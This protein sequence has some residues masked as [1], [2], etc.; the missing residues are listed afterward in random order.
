MGTQVMH[1]SYT[2]KA[3][4]VWR[5]RYDSNIL[6]VSLQT[7]DESIA[8]QRSAMLTIRFMELVSM[9]VVFVGMRET[10]KRYRDE[11]VRRDKLKIL[12]SLMA[13]PEAS[14]QANQGVIMQSLT[15]EQKVAQIALERE[16][17]TVAGHTLEEAKKAFFDANTEWKPKTIKDYSSCIDRFLVWGVANNITIIEEVSKDNIIQFKAYM[18][19]VGLASNTKQKILTR[20]GSMFNFAV[21]VKDWIAKNPIQGMMYKKVKVEH[22]KEEITPEQFNAVMEQPTVWNDNQYKWAN[23]ICYY[24]GI[25]VGELCQLTKA[26]YVEIEG[27]KCISVNTLEE[28]KSTKTES[29]IRNIPL[30]DKLLDM[31]IW[32]VKPVMKTG[33]NSVM[34]KISKSYKLIGLKRTSHCYRHSLSNRL[35]DT[36]ADDSTRAFIL[37]HA[38]ATMTDRVYVTREPLIKMQRAL[39]EAN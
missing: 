4:Y 26:D 13:S 33:L 16:L 11:L 39:N 31:G 3:G 19:E 30:C 1:T 28:G 36:S 9:G 14:Q 24:T 20:L 18:D 6:S 7:Q 37:G 12:T 32:N 38:Q 25:R 27:I 15:Q 17:E 29:S 8:T 5:K 10:L 35:R 2:K 21:D 22:P 34:D 23:A